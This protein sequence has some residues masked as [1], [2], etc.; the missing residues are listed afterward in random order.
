MSIYVEAYIQGPLDELWE[1][2]QNPALHERWDARFTSI[3]YLSRHDDAELQRFV[4]S[5]RIGFDDKD[6]EFHIQVE[7]ANSTWGRLFGYRGSFVVNNQ[8]IEQGKIPAHILPT[9]E[10][11]RE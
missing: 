7:V 3:N 4:Y 9:R 5:T 2:T 10:E 11:R 1:K 8:K 6:E